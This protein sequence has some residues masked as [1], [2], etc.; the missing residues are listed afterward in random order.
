MKK[1]FLFLQGYGWVNI[2][3]IVSIQEHND[4]NYFGCLIKLINGV[5]L[6]G[7]SKKDNNQPVPYDIEGFEDYLDCYDFSTQYQDYLMIE[8]KTLQKRL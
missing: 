8:R 7:L 1:I 5:K 2:N 4:N 6:I 3:H